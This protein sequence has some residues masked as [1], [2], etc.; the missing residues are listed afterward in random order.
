MSQWSRF[1]QGAITQCTLGPYI[2]CK[3]VHLEYLLIQ[4]LWIVRVDQFCSTFFGIIG[5][6]KIVQYILMVVPH[7]RIEPGC[8]SQ[9]LPRML[10]WFSQVNPLSEPQNFPQFLEV[11][12]K[13]D[14][15]VVNNIFEGTQGDKREHRDHTGGFSEFFI[16][17][18]P[19]FQPEILILIFDLVAVMLIAT[20]PQFNTS[21]KHIQYTLNNAV[22]RQ[23]LELLVPNVRITWTV[24]SLLDDGSQI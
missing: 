4:G 7:Q 6:G 3:I 13:V 23:F 9:V 20:F 19:P 15:K 2:E 22:E 17:Q 14:V 11:V 12:R 21:L 24:K 1:L 10:H 5:D 8:P 16:S 18:I